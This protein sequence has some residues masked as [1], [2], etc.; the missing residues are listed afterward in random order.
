MKFFRITKMLTAVAIVAGLTAAAVPLLNDL[1]SRHVLS[2]RVSG[3]FDHVSR[4]ELEAVVR[5]QLATAGFFTVNVE[6]VRHAAVSLPWVRDVTVRRVWPDSVHIAVEER[7]A[8]ARWNG[9]SLL[10]DDASVFQPREGAIEYALPRLSGPPDQ[11]LRVLRQFKHLSAALGA[12]GGGVAGVSLSARGQWEVSFANGMTVVP[13]TPFDV[14]ALMQFSR[15]LPSILGV[16]MHRAARID[17]RY[18]NGF[19]VRWR[20]AKALSDGDVASEGRAGTR[21]GKG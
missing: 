9:D 20:E 4:L 14:A 19:A 15:M 6:S 18:A 12:I 1:L 16:D 5:E 10:E 2:V 8:V 21:G 3:T 7:A 13:S 11:H 17:L